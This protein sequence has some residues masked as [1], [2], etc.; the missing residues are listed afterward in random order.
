MPQQRLL[1]MLDLSPGTIVTN[2]GHDRQVLTDHTLELHTVEPKSTITVQ[3][4]HL[5]AGACK[6]CGH[7]KARPRPQTAH[8]TWIE[9]VAGLVDIDNT[10]TV[11]HNIAAV[12]HHRRLFINKVAYLTAKTHRMNRYRI[13]AHRHLITLHDSLFLSTNIGEPCIR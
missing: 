1:G 11:A 10:P 12:A 8:G 2:N 5:L 3:N 4:Q 13:R 9:P 6:L 7:R